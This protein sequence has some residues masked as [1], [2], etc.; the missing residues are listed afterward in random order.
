MIPRL[1]FQTYPTRELPSR[2][3]ES[4]DRNLLNAQGWHYQRYSDEDIVQFIGAHYGARMLRRY[5]SISAE[6]GAA[7]ADLFRYLLI[8]ARGGVYLDIKTA[9]T[10][11]L[12]EVIAPSDTFLLGQWGDCGEDRCLDWGQYPETAPFGGEFQQWFIAA[13]PGHP[14]LKAVLRQV[15]RNID[16]YLPALQGTGKPGVLRV[17]GP[18]AYTKAIAPLMTRTPHRRVRSHTDLGLSYSVFDDIEAHYTLFQRHYSTF[19]SPIVCIGRLRSAL[20]R[21]ATFARN[22]KWPGLR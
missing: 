13:S 7:R 8:F 1:L 3:A 12:C 19:Q 11:P 16:L 6:Y 5:L 14:F 20:N 4:V 17:T 2:L 15:C 10:R 9:V 22:R 18:I 21:L